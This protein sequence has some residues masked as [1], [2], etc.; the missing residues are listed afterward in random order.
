[1]AHFALDRLGRFVLTGP[2][3][4]YPGEFGEGV[5][6]VLID[7]RNLGCNRLEV[8]TRRE[9]AG[10]LVGILADEIGVGL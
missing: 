5:V 6:H 1:M 9:T 2:A 8:S 7:H 4:V 3:E 10:S